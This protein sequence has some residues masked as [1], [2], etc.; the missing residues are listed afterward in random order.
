MNLKVKGFFEK[1]NVREEMMKIMFANVR[2]SNMNAMVES[3]EKN[4][5]KNKF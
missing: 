3:Q 5:M 4:K 2:S 1:L